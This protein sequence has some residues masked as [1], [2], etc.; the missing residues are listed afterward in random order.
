MECVSEDE[1]YLETTSFYEDCEVINSRNTIEKE[2]FDSVAETK[3]SE[4]RRCEP[5]RVSSDDVPFAGYDSSDN[6]VCPIPIDSRILY[7]FQSR[8]KR[9]TG[10]IYTLGGSPICRVQKSRLGQRRAIC[11]ML[12]IV[13]SREYT[14]LSKIATLKDVVFDI[15]QDP[16]VC[17]QFADGCI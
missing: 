12:V 10:G 14:R 15:E 13:R 2:F 11:D 7:K 4:N 17:G 8:S 1:I 6:C 16:A 9:R 5:R 3:C